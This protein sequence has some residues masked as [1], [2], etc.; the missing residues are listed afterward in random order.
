[1]LA[2]AAI[3]SGCGDDTSTPKDQSQVIAK[4]NG[5]EITIM[6]LNQLLASQPKVDEKI[7]KQLLDKLIDQE[8]LVQK[9]EEL[10]L[11]RNPEILQNI[12]YA[13]RQVLAQAAASK[14]IGENSEPSSSDIKN[15]YTTNAAMFENRS[16]FD[17]D[18]FVINQSDAS[19]LVNPELQNSTSSIITA[20]ILEKLGVSYKQNHAKRYSEQLPEAIVKQLNQIKEGDMIKTSGENNEVVLMQLKS[21][22]PLPVSESDAEQTIRQILINKNLQEKMQEKMSVIRNNSKIELVSDLK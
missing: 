8:L 6:Q 14:L 22:L 13:K 3:I 9:S 16:L 21:R 7:K 2:A 5:K 18:V 15:Y 20:Q 4:V 17:L 19:K 10:K 11:D 1:M 12:E